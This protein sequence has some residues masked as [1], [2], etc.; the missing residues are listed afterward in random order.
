MEIYTSR[1]KRIHLGETA[2]Q[3]GEATVYQ[4]L[5]Q[6]DE[7]AKI[8][9]RAPRPEY[10][11]KLTWMVSHPPEN[12]TQ[13]L[14]HDS[15]AWP[16]DLLYDSPRLASRRFVGY[17]MPH[18]REATPILHVFNPRLRAETLPKFD[19]RYLHRV[20]RNLAAALG[21]LH[22]FGY[23]VGDLNESNVLVTSTALVT[24]I[25]TDSFQVE[26]ERNGRKVVHFCPVGKPDYTP[27]ELQ[28]QALGQEYRKPQHD[29]FGL[30][31]L[32]FQLLMDGNHPFRAQWMGSGDPPPLEARISMGCFPYSATTPYPV[33][34]PKNGPELSRLHPAVADLVLQC[35]ID[36]HQAPE[37]RPEPAV[38]E[39]AIAEAEKALIACGRG[40]YFSNHLAECPD[41]RRSTRRAGTAGRGVRPAAR[42]APAQD[43]TGRRPAQA[44]TAAAPPPPSPAGGRQG[45]GAGRGQASPPF[46]VRIFR[47]AMRNA[48]S[49][50]RS[51]RPNPPGSG[52]GPNPGAAGGTG[53]RGGWGQGQ[54]PRPGSSSGQPRPSGPGTPGRGAPQPLVQA[55]QIFQWLR[56]LQNQPASG[57]GGAAAST[58]WAGSQ[59]AW[60]LGSRPWRPSSSLRRSGLPAGNF[61]VTARRQTGR[62]LVFGGGGGA[63]LGLAL[64]AL[65]AAASGALGFPMEWGPLLAVGGAAGGMLRGWR[66]G[67]RFGLWVSR[68]IGWSYFWQGV[69]ILAG[70]AIGLLLSL[71]FGMLIFPLFLG[72]F[73]GGRAGYSIG[74][75]LWLT[76]APYGW[77]RIWAGMSAVWTAI[78]GVFL[79]NW[80]ASTGLGEQGI[81]LANEFGLWVAAQTEG[82]AV[83]WLATGALGGAAGGLIAGFIVDLIA[84]AFGLID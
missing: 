39:R 26:E 75:K 35:F 14:K 82:Q 73:A 49:Q 23:V 1:G 30:G 81:L 54:P 84:R 61:W 17:T 10:R 79:I 44:G 31:V 43:R 28:G 50:V 4:M 2:G 55:L 53:S 15:L 46:S 76:G 59:S 33:Q 29:A 68:R 5:G 21:A 12:P 67:Y 27:P 22:R 7:L 71:P 37:R 72:L 20:A 24:L 18:I 56:G 36:G 13:S 58:T 42:E 11:A 52:S 8:Y 32:I 45:A 3:G 77:E 48:L 83:V 25:D 66:P 70:A 69:G 57:P 47:W 9:T 6:P 65:L 34:P 19:R 64:C 60:G 74:K 62:S 63:L 78:S 38:W 80:L 16:T 40:H 41:C 51:A